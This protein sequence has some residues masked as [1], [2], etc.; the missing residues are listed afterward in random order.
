MTSQTIVTPQ[1][2]VQTQNGKRFYVFSGLVAVAVAETTVLDINNIG[3]R[4]IK[5]HLE[6]GN[7]ETADQD[8][9]TRIY[10]NNILIYKNYGFLRTRYGTDTQ[11]LTFILPANTSFKASIENVTS[12]CNWT[13]TGYGRYLS[14]E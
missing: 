11:D 9:F 3:E 14:S 13:I 7:D 5:L 2:L 10:S 6:F 4:D 8:A 12:T 1:S